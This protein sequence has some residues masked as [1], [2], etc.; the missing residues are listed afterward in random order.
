MTLC[1]T[2]EDLNPQLNHCEN[3]KSHNTIVFVECGG[4]VRP[5]RGPIPE[6]DKSSVHLVTL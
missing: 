1:Y 2:P 4:S 6:P 3:L 5:A